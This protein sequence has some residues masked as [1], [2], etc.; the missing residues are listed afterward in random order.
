[1]A[2]VG[3]IVIDITADIGPLIKETDRAAGKLEGFKGRVASLGSALGKVSAVT[4]TWGRKLSIVSG[5][6]AAAA[7]AAL[8]LAKNAAETGDAIGDA[9]AAAGVSTDYFQEMAFAMG[10]AADMSREDFAA[11]M[12]RL[13]RTLGEAQQGSKGAIKAFEAIGISQEAIAAGT[14][15]TEEAFDAYIAKMDGMRDPALAAAVSADLFGK[16][17]AAM[18]GQ[19]VGAGDAVSDLRDRARELGIVMSKD[20]V[21]AAG[22]FD[23]K[24]R[25]LTGSLEGLRLKVASELLPV[26]TKQLIPAVTDHL[27][28]ALVVLVD[29]VGN[30]IEWFGNL[31]APVQ[32]AAAIIAGAFAVGGPILLGISMVSAAFTALIAATG[33]I[34]LFIAAAG[35]AAAAWV[36]WGDDFKA[37][38]GA[39]IDWVSGKFDAFIAK[40]QSI[41][42]KAK[43][44]AAAVGEAL[45]SN[46]GIGGGVTMQNENPQAGWMGDQFGPGHITGGGG[47]N[48]GTSVI[49]GIVDGMGTRLAE[50]RPEIDE[51]INSIPQA[52]RDLLE[53]HSPSRVFEEIGGFIGEGLA[54]GIARSQ[55]V[56]AASVGAI[57]D[58]AVSSTDGMVSDILGGLNTL[59][60][61][62]KGVSAG[63]AWIS[64]LVGAAK[65]LEKGTFGFAT[66]AAVLAKGAAFVAAIS[67][68][69]KSGG[70]KAVGG[71]TGNQGG[72]QGGRGGQGVYYNVQLNGGPVF[73]KDQM[74]GLF[75]MMNKEIENGRR[76]K[77]IRFV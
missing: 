14:V 24:W 17:G 21:D 35:L 27:I 11:A 29:K 7:G 58:T 68:T 64:T 5:A 74:R 60:G 26:L 61:K 59:F 67:S 65:E 31:P 12:T 8:L 54:N 15:S 51:M 49:D 16:A 73:G 72:N 33:P 56:V 76:I 44:V 18:G 66:A 39:A 45:M 23:A 70:R 20:A 30:A 19:L 47:G 1:M 63:I 38:I 9:A 32:E 28:P 52:A 37:A 10:T 25:E 50:R 42:E 69:S 48:L 40:L 46:G 55:A 43:E 62:S 13:A 57:S 6:V 77:G 34:G 22:E 3:D 75:E 71:G 2:T 41:V 4:E 36:T 53:I